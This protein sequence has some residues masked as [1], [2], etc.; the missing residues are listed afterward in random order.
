MPRDVSTRWNVTY[1][2]LLFALDFRPAIDS[3]TALCD[4]DLQRYELS[5]AEWGI[6]KELRDILKVFL[7]PTPF[8]SCLLND[9][10]PDFQ[11][12]NI[13]FFLQHPKPCHSHPGNG[14]YQQSPCHLL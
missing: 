2:M 12:C 5:P 10:W 11:R 3:M 13:I 4:F 7:S 8:D 14:S 9:L 6:A 1:D